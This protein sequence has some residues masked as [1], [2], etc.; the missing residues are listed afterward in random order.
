ME[1]ILENVRKDLK[2]LVNEKHRESAQRFFKEDV[3]ILGVPNA[4]VQKVSAKYVN[5]LKK[6]SKAEVFGLC[7]ELWKTNIM[8]ECM[9]ACHWS[10][11]MKKY[12]SVGDIK[13][14][15][16]W[17]S[18]YITNW[19]TCDTLCNHTVGELIELFPELTAYLKKWTA[20]K[21]RWMR[22]A[23]AVSLIVP[24]KKGLFLD[25][26]QHIAG[27]LLLDKDD[28]VQ[29]GYGWM[30]KESSIPHQ[31]S[32]YEFV[33]KHKNVMPRTA[34]R[35]AIEKMPAHLKAEAMKK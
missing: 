31:K 13:V 33:I 22:R 29:K 32:I 17:V 4:V 3:S 2:S 26:I 15:E 30:L 23:A 12:Y 21:N 28:L 18:K 25:D 11:R 7:T 1:K 9:I 24:A 8:E 6:L 27:L 34:L 14:F 35:Y 16:Q 19:A 20:S 10:Y 5:D